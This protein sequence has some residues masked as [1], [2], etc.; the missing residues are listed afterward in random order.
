[1]EFCITEIAIPNFRKQFTK[2][3]VSSCEILGN[4]TR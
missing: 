4:F 1:M 3:P 2:P